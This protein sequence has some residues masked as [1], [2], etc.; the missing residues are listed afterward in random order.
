MD[1]ASH[2]N[3]NADVQGKPRDDYPPRARECPAFQFH[4]VLRTYFT[5]GRMPRTGGVGSMG[6]DWVG[7]VRF[8]SAVVY[9]IEGHWMHR[10]ALTGWPGPRRD[11]LQQP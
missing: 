3:G 8:D 11:N 7:F 10:G 2:R 5:A 4:S 6:S 9:V 1:G